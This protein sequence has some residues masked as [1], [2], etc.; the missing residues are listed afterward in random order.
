MA[1]D[2]YTGLKGQSDTCQIMIFLTDWDQPF[3]VN[4][5][6]GTFVDLDNDPSII[7]FGKL[8]DSR[9]MSG[10][11]QFEIELDY[12]DT[13]RKPKYIVITA[14]S[15]KYGDYFTGGVGSMLLVDE[16]ELVYR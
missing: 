5:N 13:V 10:Y 4:T 8:E 16:F 11:E 9:S 2:P 6:T 1:K 14:C 12:R 3:T 15:S 7:A